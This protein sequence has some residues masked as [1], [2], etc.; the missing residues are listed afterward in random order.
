METEAAIL[1]AKF[2]IFP[3]ELLLRKRVAEKYTQLIEPIQDVE[4]PIIPSHVSSSW[5]IYSILASD[6]KHRSYLQGKLKEAGVPTAVY[7]PKPLHIQPAFSYLGYG[8]NDFPVSENCAKR[9]FSLPM[10]PYLSDESQEQIA[11]ILRS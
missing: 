2:E 5:A 3:E 7:Y 11:G 4:T 10:H 9:I 6:E 1:L 8:E